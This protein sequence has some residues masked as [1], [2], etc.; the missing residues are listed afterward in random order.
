MKFTLPGLPPSVN[1]SH[2]ARGRKLK[3]ETSRWIL[4]AG[5]MM[6]GQMR[7]QE[8]L[9]KG[10]LSL[11]VALYG[12]WFTKTGALRRV[13][14]SN[15]IKLLEDLVAKLCGFDDSAVSILKAEKIECPSEHTVVEVKVL[16]ASSS[17]AAA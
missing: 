15:R 17:E 5:L 1:H 3:P 8:K 13:D 6:R 9:T 7:G 2:F 14:L 4:N 16:R 10:E 11:D 12:Q